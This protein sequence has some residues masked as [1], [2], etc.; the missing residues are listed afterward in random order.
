MRILS[1]ECSAGAASSAVCGDGKLLSEVFT[2][3]SLTHSRTLMRCIDSAL[4]CAEIGLETIDAFAVSNGPGSF[5]GIR[6]GCAA[7]KGLAQA[8]EKPCIPISTL[9]GIAYALCGM[10]G[11]ACAAMDARCGQV[12]TAS[13]DCSAG[14]ERLCPDQA[15]SI[16]ELGNFLKNLKKKIF[17]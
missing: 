16:E 15:V 10:G 13:F 12:Y 7:V 3:T 4:K 17:L 8:G 9:E 6:I 11:V 5:T 14:L 1:V 2:N